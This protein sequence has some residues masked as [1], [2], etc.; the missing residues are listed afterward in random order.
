MNRSDEYY[1]DLA[2]QLAREAMDTNSGGPFGAIIVKDGVIVGKG[3]NEVT[4][5]NDPTAHAEINAIRHACSELKTFHLS[6]ATIYSTCEPCAMCLGA[7]YWAKIE[8]VVFSL[9]Q[10]HAAEIAGFE[11]A[12]IY[13]EMSLPWEKRKLKY[14]TIS[15]VDCYQLFQE[16]K[17]KDD[18]TMY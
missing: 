11:D 7:I 4:S 13:N 18:K 14:K 16:W 10:L 9:T 2:T 6:G 17:S 15:H 1:L 5:D 8:R 12:N 3:K